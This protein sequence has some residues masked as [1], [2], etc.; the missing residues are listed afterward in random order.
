M[1]KIAE[2]V[3]KSLSQ[4]KFK[5]DFPSKSVKSAGSPY[6]FLEALGRSFSGLSPWLELTQVEGKEKKLQAY[7]QSL[8][9]VSIGNA[10]SPN[11]PDYMEFKEGQQPLVDAAFLAHGLLR[12]WN[13]IWCKLDPEIQGYVVDAMKD[14]RTRKPYSNNWL[15]FSGIIEAFLCKAGCSDWDPRRIDYAL[16]QHEQ[17]YLGDGCYGDGPDFHW[18]YYNSYVIMPML[19]DILEADPRIF[20]LWQDFYGPTLKRFK[21]QTKIQER[22]IAPDGTFPP[23]GR[24]ICYR[25]GAFQ[26]LA[27][28]A[29]KSHLDESLTPS[30]VR[31]ALTA[32]LQKVFDS[33]TTFDKDG[34]LTLGLYGEQTNLA[35]GYIN[36]GSVYLCLCAFLPLGL[37]S[38]APFWSGPVSDWTSKQIWEGRNIAKDQAYSE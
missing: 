27:Q 6:R 11:S 34:W 12:S 33:K 25:S 28:G 23:I 32:M 17:W 8:V 38:S 2:P 19:I 18:D 16:R 7:W 4:Q 1:L 3:Y 21:R 15:L 20:D 31:S 14:T 22:L 9:K 35:E 24:S 37:P 36:K 29:L 10:V 26:L 30:R 13:Q 5:Q